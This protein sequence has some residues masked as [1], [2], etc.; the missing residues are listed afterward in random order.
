LPTCCPPSCLSSI[1]WLIVCTE[2]SSLPS[3]FLWCTF[4]VPTPS[5]VLDYSFLVFI[6]IFGGRVSLPKGCAGLWGLGGVLHDMWPSPVCSV[7][8][9]AGRFGAGCGNCSCSGG[10]SPQIFSV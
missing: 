1:C 6:Q 7:K 10:G 8:C 4:S 9:L 5:D 2:I 3:P